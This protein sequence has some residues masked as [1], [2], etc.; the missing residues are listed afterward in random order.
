[1]LLHDVLVLLDGTLEAAASLGAKVPPAYVAT[2]AVMFSSKRGVVAQFDV[3]PHWSCVWR[4]SMNAAGEALIDKYHDTGMAL[5]TL[6]Y[7]SKN[8]FTLT[9][10]SVTRRSPV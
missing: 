6:A 4:R 2:A 3:D 8:H 9:R 5:E 1:M 10:S 7:A